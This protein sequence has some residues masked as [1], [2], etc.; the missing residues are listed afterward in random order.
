MHTVVDPLRLNRMQ[1]GGAR[2]LAVLGNLVAVAIAV[3]TDFDSHHPVF[4][5]GAAGACIAPLIVTM[6]PRRHRLLFYLGAYGGLPALA[7]LQAYSGGAASG[8]SVLMMM[9]MI[10]F[11]LQATDRELLAGLAVLAASSYLPMLVFGPPAYPVEW[12][13]ATLLV[14]V[15]AT[16]AGSL[17]L[18]TR[19]TKRLTARLQREAVQDQLTGLLNRRGWHEA[20]SRGLARAGRSGAPVALLT[21]DLDRLKQINDSMGHD[22]GDRTLRQ[23]G[24]RLLAMVR[25]GDVLARLGGDEFVALLTDTTLD[26]ALAAVERL[27]VATPSIGHFSAGVAVWNRSEDLDGLVRR[28]DVALYAAKANPGDE[29]EVAVLTPSSPPTVTLA[30]AGRS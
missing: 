22:V 5:Y 1:R 9:A 16:V 30:A 21:L 19:E 11:G 12:G 3:A 15:G 13:N 4:F 17:R 25:D 20:A 14:L 23:T 27:R 8:Y 26:G 24:G 6:V 18:V 7:M 28:C 2:R 10:W 29:T